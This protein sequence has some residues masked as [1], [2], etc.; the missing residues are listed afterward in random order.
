MANTT[1]LPSHLRAGS[2]PSGAA[3]TSTAS[4]SSA[5]PPS[6]TARIAEKKAELENLRELRDLSGQLAGQ[7]ETLEAK[8]ATLS[9]GTEAVAT[10]LGNWGAVLK[11]IHM[12]S[13]MFCFGALSATR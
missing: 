1:R 8:L 11:S 3:G 12:A 5:V 4:S 10:V 9:S 2:L 7:M 6:L 13:G